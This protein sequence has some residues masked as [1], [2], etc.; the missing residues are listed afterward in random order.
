MVSMV[1]M[2][3]CTFNGRLRHVLRPDEQENEN[4]QRRL[5]RWSLRGDSD[6]ASDRDEGVSLR[7]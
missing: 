5:Q 1:G 3:T 2:V 6:K 4:L 7:Q